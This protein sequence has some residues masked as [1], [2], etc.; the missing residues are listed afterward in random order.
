MHL[1][2]H[3]VVFICVIKVL[4]I[5]FNFI[6]MIASLSNSFKPRNGLHD[7]SAHAEC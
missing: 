5:V 1:I 7:D 6:F 4:L 3:N 2:V